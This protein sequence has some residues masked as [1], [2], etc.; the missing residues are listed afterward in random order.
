MIADEKND[1]GVKQDA[2]KNLALLKDNAGNYKT[3]FVANGILSFADG[4]YYPFLIAFLYGLG[5]IPLLGAGL[6]LVLIFESLGSYF[7]GKWADKYGRKLFFLLSSIISI[8]V[9][10][11]Y[12]LLPLIDETGRSLMF[13]VL[14][15]TLIIN[16]IVDGFWGIAEAAYLADIT[17][18]VSRGRK[19]GSYWGVSGLITGA[20]M[21]GAGFLG[22]YIDFLTAALIIVLIYSSGFIMLLRIKEREAKGIYHR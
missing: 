21:L 16:G 15:L 22:L 20:A 19:M 17:S 9:F 13:S 4:L 10:L 1:A 8:I 12:P 14:F 7:A 5:G 18:K 6:G 11:A 3:I 2:A